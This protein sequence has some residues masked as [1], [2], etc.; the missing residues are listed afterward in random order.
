VRLLNGVLIHDLLVAHPHGV[1]IV[2]PR[3]GI[4]RRVTHAILSPSLD[5]NDR[6]TALDVMLN[7]SVRDVDVQQQQEGALPSWS[8]AGDFVTISRGLKSLFR[9]S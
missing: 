7:E 3:P 8:M 6:C 2:L 5:S 9:R 4:G 1:C